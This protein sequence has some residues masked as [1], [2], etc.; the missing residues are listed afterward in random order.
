[1]TTSWRLR[2]A[3]EADLE[4]L[5]ALHAATGDPRQR[6]EGFVQTPQEARQHVLGHLEHARI[7]VLDGRDI[8]LMKLVP[9]RPDWQLWQ[10]QLLPGLR[11]QGL[12]GA[13]LHHAIAEAA[14]AGC[15]VC[16]TLPDD[17]PA[18][19]LYERFGFRETG[20]ALHGIVLRRPLG[21]PAA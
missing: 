14:A 18:R 4:F 16:V 13:L 10:L 1:M 6:A 9:A 3:T 17:H 11:R 15:G 21:A 20:P 8:G 7:V 12:G 2:P 5:L 19:R